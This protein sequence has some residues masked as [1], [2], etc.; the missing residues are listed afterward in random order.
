MPR[1]IEVGAV[2]CSRLQ[3]TSVCVC[4]S[5]TGIAVRARSFLVGVR[6]LTTAHK[7]TVHT[8]SHTHTHIHTHTCAQISLFSLQYI[9]SSS[10]NFCMH[11]QV[12]V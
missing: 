10:F 8:H 6:E 9:F 2:W 1:S 12:H 7:G 11:L 3:G 4:V 5:L